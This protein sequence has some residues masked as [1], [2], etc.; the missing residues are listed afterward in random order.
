MASNSLNTPPTVS[1]RP[2][3]LSSTRTRAR[4]FGQSSSS[5]RVS[6]A[7]ASLARRPVVVGRR[8]DRRHRRHRRTSS[9]NPSARASAIAHRLHRRVQDVPTR[10]LARHRASTLARATTTGTW[11]RA[12]RCRAPRGVSSVKGQDSRMQSKSTPRRVVIG[13]S[14]HDPPCRRRRRARGDGARGDGGG[15]TLRR[16]RTRSTDAHD[17]YPHGEMRRRDRSRRRGGRGARRARGA[18]SARSARADAG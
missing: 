10:S 12:S 15:A 9:R 13:E 16:A 7:S 2:R 3:S 6:F 5:V 1:P 17:V 18:S 4:G 11:R 8:R 14:T